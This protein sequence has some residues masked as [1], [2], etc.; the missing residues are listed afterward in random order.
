YLDDVRIYGSALSNEEVRRIA[1]IDVDSDG[2]GLDDN[3][4]RAAFG[5]LDRNGVGDFDGDRLSDAAEHHWGTD[6]AYRDTDRDGLW[7]GEEVIALHTNPVAV[8]TDHDGLS[9]FDEFE[10]HK[11]DP[12]AGDTDR[13]GM[14][15]GWELDNGASPTAY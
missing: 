10:T 14:L 13:D 3:W 15:D 12:L 1:Q 11:T 4:E 2:D 5:T 9:D 8:D 7:D 6:P